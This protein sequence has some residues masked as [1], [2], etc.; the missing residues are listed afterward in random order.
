[1]AQEN[2]FYFA[3]EQIRN[4]WTEALFKRACQF[5]AEEQ[6]ENEIWYLNAILN[7]NGDGKYFS[8][9]IKENRVRSGDRKK[10]LLYDLWNEEDVRLNIARLLHEVSGNRCSIHGQVYL[11][12]RYQKGR[13][14]G[15]SGHQTFPD[16]F[17]VVKKDKEYNNKAKEKN[18]ESGVVEIKYF[19]IGR[20]KHYIKEYALKDIKK[21]VSYCERGLKPPAD[22]GFFI[23]IDETDM[24]GDILKELFNQKR[25]RR[26][27]IAFA[28]ITP[29]YAREKRSYPR[30]YEKTEQ[31]KRKLQYVM[32]AALGKIACNIGGYMPCRISDDKWSYFFWL[33]DKLRRRRGWVALVFKGYSRHKKYSL[34]IKSDRHLKKAKSVSWNKEKSYYEYTDEPKKE[35]EY[36]WL[37]GRNFSNLKKTDEIAKDIARNVRLLHRKIAPGRL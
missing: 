30:K 8:E 37:R 34:I 19:T 22:G 2:L 12:K 35:R 3:N 6:A 17:F 28:V 1:M 25:F 36:R 31:S 7:I 15:S 4:E 13:K 23:C 32:D 10:D 18:V 11:K 29:A 16:L 20:Q 27:P 24:A 26:K 14:K 5:F 33:K 21:L 9:V